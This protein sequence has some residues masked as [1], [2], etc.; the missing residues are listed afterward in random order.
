MR[1]HI[2]SFVSFCEFT[3]LL[4]LKK[5]QYSSL[6]LC[7]NSF[8]ILKDLTICKENLAKFVSLF[9]EVYFDRVRGNII[10][11]YILELGLVLFV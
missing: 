8:L 5:M 11:Q 4:T 6:S 9:S 10:G 2:S 3:L 1:V 7:A